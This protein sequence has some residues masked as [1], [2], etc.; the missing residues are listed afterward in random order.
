M[1]PGISREIV[2]AEILALQ[3]SS[4]ITDYWGELK[5]RDGDKKTVI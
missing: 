4:G 1:A 2:M 3:L 5:I